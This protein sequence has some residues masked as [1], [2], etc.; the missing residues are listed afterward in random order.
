MSTSDK[1]VNQK[2]I[3]KFINDPN[4]F[5]HIILSQWKP[6]RIETLLTMTITLGRIEESSNAG[7]L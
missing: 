3:G 6:K 1:S 4:V 7:I 2:E 5:N